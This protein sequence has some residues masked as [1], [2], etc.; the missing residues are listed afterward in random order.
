MKTKITLMLVLF[1]AMTSAQTQADQTWDS[2]HHVFSEG[3]EGY[4]YMYND[5]T[6]DITGGSVNEFFMYDNTSADISGGYIGVL[7]GQNTSEVNVRNGSDIS[8]LRPN[9][10]S[11]A[12]V[13]GGEISRLF[14]LGNSI[15]N[16]HEG[17]FGRFSANDFALI[18]MYAE[19]EYWDPEGGSDLGFGSL[20]GTWL[21]SG[22]PFT[23]DNVSDD[24]Y[25]NN[26]IIFVP[27][28]NFMSLFILSAVFLK[29]RKSRTSD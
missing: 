10:F 14:V 22:N 25:N 16:I 29:R 11:V 3:H 23:I 5:A 18:K 9:D 8:L 6:A 1:L 26:H 27:E 4:I 2:G 19:N 7:L 21:S 17:E 13:Y 20:S 24:C 12:N 28:P 15:T